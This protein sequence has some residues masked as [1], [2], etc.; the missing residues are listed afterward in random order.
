MS[1]QTITINVQARGVK[2]TTRKMDGLGASLKRAGRAAKDAAFGMAIVGGAVAVAGRKLIEGADAYTN[3]TN[4]TKVFSTSSGQAAFKM[5]DTINIARKMNASLSEVGSVYQRI[6]MVQQGA[7]FDDDTASKMVENLTKAVKLSGA[8]AQEAEG[9]LRQFAQGLAANRLSGQELNS[10]LEQTPMIAQLLAQKLG[11]ATGALRQ[12]GKDGLLTTKVL[13]DTFGGSIDEL[14]K[15]FSKFSFTLESQMVSVKRELTLASGKMMHMAKVSSGLGEVIK[16]LATGPLTRL[17]ATLE[18]GG[19]AADN[20]VMWFKVALGAA[21]GVATVAIVGFI[22]VIVG[23]L[24]PLAAA[25]LAISAVAGAMFAYQKAALGNLESLNAMIDK[26]QKLTDA[27]HKGT[28]AYETHARQLSFLKGKREELI[29]SMQE[30]SKEADRT[31]ENNAKTMKSFVEGALTMAEAR[32]ALRYGADADAV[33]ELNRQKALKETEA[34]ALEAAEAQ[35]KAQQKLIKEY[36]TAGNALRKYRQDM[37]T[38]GSM[39]DELDEGT[40]IAMAKGIQAAFDATDPLVQAQKEL[41]ELQDALKDKHDKAG[42]AL[43]TYNEEMDVLL[44]LQGKIETEV[45][46]RMAQSIRDARDEAMG[47]NDEFNAIVANLDAMGRAGDK[48]K[49]ELDTG[50]KLSDQIQRDSGN[51]VPQLTSSYEEDNKTLKTAIS[52][53]AGTPEQIEAM[54]EALELRRQA[55]E[56]D[57]LENEHKT[58]MLELNQGLMDQ[59]LTMGELSKGVSA[60]MAQGFMNVAKETMNISGQ[61][62]Q[63]T[64]MAIGGLA[65]GIASLATGGKANFKEL[66]LAF[67]K[68]IIQMIVKL[69]VMMALITAISLIPGGSAVLQMMG[70]GAGAAPGAGAASPTS[71]GAGGG[72]FSLE[73]PSIAGGINSNLLGR[74]ASGGPVGGGTPI[75]VGERGPELFVPPTSGSIKNNTTT[76]GMMQQ[77]APEVTVVNV[78]ST[79]N[80]LDALGS[81]EGENLIM[82]VIQR[83]PEILRSLG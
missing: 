73:A 47:L 49:S 22:A 37:E 3:L 51:A 52:S 15:K 20:L 72:G 9:A 33:I 59:T 29:A 13:V 17:N 34:I 14:E 42:T 40:F 46:N 63:M 25:V 32:Q 6:S 38:L 58:S 27:A 66:G 61:I 71:A 64:S 7:G 36:D 8:T 75:L 55:H 44:S 45:Y 19:P 18:A 82:N 43:R 11:V 77:K 54:Q 1:E 16:D 79:Q 12:M 39:I 53:G 65:D 69:T 21:A 23:M 35:A 31:R 41:I 10:V 5:Q 57:L 50:M 67:V 4:Q 74:K 78:D 81:E 83:N 76:Q 2:T 28:G 62:T 56:L 60:S 26:Q 48:S 30:E 70:M 68:M 80:T 24:T